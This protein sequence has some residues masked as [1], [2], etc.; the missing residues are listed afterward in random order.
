[1]IGKYYLV[2]NSSSIWYVIEWRI[3]LRNRQVCAHMRKPNNKLKTARDHQKG[4][5]L[6]RQKWTSRKVA[7]PRDQE[8]SAKHTNLVYTGFKRIR[9]RSTGNKFLTFP[10]HNRFFVNFTKDAP[11]FICVIVWRFLWFISFFCTSF[12]LSGFDLSI[13]SEKGL[14]SLPEPDH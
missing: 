3:N 1:M 8:R 9:R 14:Y 6:T 12:C 7:T 13:S 4:Q 10:L 5:F 11:R 2:K